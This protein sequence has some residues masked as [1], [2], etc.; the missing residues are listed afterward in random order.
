MH[1]HSEHTTVEWKQF[2][3]CIWIYFC[4]LTISKDIFSIHF[5]SALLQYFLAFMDLINTLTGKIDIITAKPCIPPKSLFQWIWSK[6]PKFR[7]NFKFSLTLFCIPMR[8]SFVPRHFSD[9]GFQ[10]CYVST[11]S[12]W[13]FWSVTHILCAF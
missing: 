1:K 4:T 12:L 5:F 7:Y 8:Q 10:A 6:N 2:W 11:K 9:R 13:R 3:N